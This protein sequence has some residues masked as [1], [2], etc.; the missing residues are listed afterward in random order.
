MKKIISLCLAA[1]LLAVSFAGCTNSKENNSLNV[2]V[3]QYMS[4]PSLDNCYNGVEQALK[5]SG[6]D[7]KIDHQTG[8]SASADA[9]CATYAQNMVSKKYDLIIAIATPAAASAYAKTDGTDIPVVFCAVSDPVAAKLVKTLQN[10]GTPCTGTTDILDLEAQ[11]DMIK[12][13]QPNVKK[14]GILYTTS[15]ANSISNLARLKE[16]ALTKGIEI[17]PSGIQNASDLPS[18]AAALCGQVD[19]I[20]NFTDNN[21]VENLPVVLNAAKSANI[22]VYG[23]EEEQVKL[24]C[25]A[26]MSLD[27]VALG[28]V[29]GEM[30]VKILNGTSASTMPV[31][32]VADA[33]PVINSEVA[34]N[35]KFE[36]PTNFANATI[37]ET[38][39]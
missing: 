27:Y 12:A 28:K 32:E 21:V 30:A 6:L 13:F 20:N 22:P 9:D 7:I 31:A 11:V 23:S 35:L 10:P 39:K 2:G 8:S 33:K 1:V 15:E 18:A 3:I 26:S 19:C 36:M 4:H 25:L 16:I 29:T 17:V 38:I 37:V 14:I 34:A 5:A 24:G